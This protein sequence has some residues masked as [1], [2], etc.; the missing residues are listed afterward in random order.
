MSNSLADILGNF[1]FDE[2]PEVAAIKQYIERS[3]KVT[4]VVQPRPRDIIITVPNGALANTL[5][6]ETTQLQKAANTK[7]K[8]VFRI[9][10]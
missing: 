7:K 8:L 10:S 2:P 1:N 3:Y 5:R 6:F 4:P 9:G